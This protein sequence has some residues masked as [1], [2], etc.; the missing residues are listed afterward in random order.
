MLM[1]MALA[2]CTAS[3]I[4]GAKPKQVYIDKNTVALELVSASILQRPGKGMETEPQSRMYLCLTRTNLSDQSEKSFLVR[5]PGPYPFADEP[6]HD[7]PFREVETSLVVAAGD[8]ADVLDGCE[9]PDGTT[10][11]KQLSILDAKPNLGVV[12]PENTK[13][14]IIVSHH[15]PH[16]LGLAYVSV[17]PVFGGHYSFA[18]DLSRSALYTEYKGPRPY[19]L[20]LTPITAVGDVVLGVA[21]V[22]TVATISAVCPEA[23]LS[24]R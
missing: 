18:I 4:D 17:V 22:F 6:R 24:C 21:I 16:G 20:L 10:L 23:F 15:G 7:Y 1:L 11:I 5:V 19:L 13:D 2:G 14:A 8:K 9:P 12:L 3:V